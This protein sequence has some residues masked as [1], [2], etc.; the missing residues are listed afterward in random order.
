LFEEKCR[1][2]VATLRFAKRKSLLGMTNV[3]W[4]WVRAD[5]AELCKKRGALRFKGK[6]NSRS[7]GTVC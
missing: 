4:E 5:A 1:F 6:G 7:L 3:G 2:L